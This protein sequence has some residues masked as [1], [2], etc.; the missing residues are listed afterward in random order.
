MPTPYEEPRPDAPAEVVTAH[1]LMGL[2]PVLL[3]LTFLAVVT[4]LVFGG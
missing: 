3:L 1:L 2:V 4:H